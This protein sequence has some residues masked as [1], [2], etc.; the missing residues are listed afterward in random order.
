MPTVQT[1]TLA[2]CECCALMVANGDES[3]C[4]AYYGY[5]HKSADV[6]AGTVLTDETDQPCHGFTCDGCGEDIA[7]FG[8]R[9]WA[10]VL[11][12]QHRHGWPCDLS[13]TWCAEC[14]TCS[15][16]CQQVSPF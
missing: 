1:D 2:L 11:E 3:G 8:Y 12:P 15:D 5:T 9:L 6:P 7:P 16:F 13:V 4:R 14:D 10:A